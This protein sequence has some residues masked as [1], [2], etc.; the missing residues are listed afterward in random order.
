MAV[1]NDGE[2]AKKMKQLRSHGICSTQ[3]EMQSRPDDEIWNYQ[4]L[5]LGFN[6]RMTELQAALGLSQ[7]KKLDEFVQKRHAIAATYNE[8]LSTLPVST[9][10]QHPDSYSSYHL[11]PIQIEAAICGKSQKEVF[12]ALYQFGIL[13]NLHYIPVYRQPYYEQ[14][15]F[16]PN[17]C[18]NAEKYYKTSISIPVYSSMSVDQQNQVIQKLRSIFL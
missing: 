13:V 4:Q 16:K 17:Y 10:I 15:G 12:Q 9:P 6:Y 2:L 7:L 14:M 18:P 8:T 5:S 1:T 11:Y 3:T